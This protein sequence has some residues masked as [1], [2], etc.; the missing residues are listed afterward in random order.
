MLSG[1][2]RMVPDVAADA[3]PSTGYNIIVHGQ[4]ETEGGTSA[5]APLYSGLF[6]AFGTKMG[7]VTPK[8]WA[9]QLCFNDITQGDNGFY[10]AGPGPGRLHR[11]R[12]A[13]RD[14]TGR[15]SGDISGTSRCAGR[16]SGR[17]GRLEWNNDIYLR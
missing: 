9:N 12:V 4:P 2:G 8:L 15:P 14:Q 10:R 7:F 3:D 5:V 13:H 16:V 1:P 6:A 11:T 17:G